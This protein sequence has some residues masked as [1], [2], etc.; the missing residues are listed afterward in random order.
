[1][2][3]SSVV[4]LL[5][6]ISYVFSVNSRVSFSDR[7]AKLMLNWIILESLRHTKLFI[8]L[9]HIGR[10]DSQGDICPNMSGL[11]PVYTCVLV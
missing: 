10:G 6:Q 9:H 1:M 2:A 4:H 7:K 11:V 8:S 3:K 5:K